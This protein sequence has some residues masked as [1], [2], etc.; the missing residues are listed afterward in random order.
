MAH[1]LTC[2]PVRDRVLAYMGK[3]TIM[4]SDNG[5]EFVNNV[6]QQ[7]VSDWPGD[8]SIIQGRPYHPQSQG[9]VERANQV[10]RQRIQS[11]MTERCS[12]NWTAWLA[13]VMCEFVKVIYCIDHTR[14]RLS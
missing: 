12:S 11:L 13:E 7:L 14:G 10:V 3:P 4:Q 1:F 9:V 8:C 2:H 6:M 5:G